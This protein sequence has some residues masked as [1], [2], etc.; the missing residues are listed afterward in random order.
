MGDSTES[1]CILFLNEGKNTD[2]NNIAFEAF[3]YLTVWGDESTGSL[4]TM[5]G[6][7]R[8]AQNNRFNKQ[9]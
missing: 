5:A 1:I 2:T 3:L 9:K 6:A 7:T 4:A 8:L